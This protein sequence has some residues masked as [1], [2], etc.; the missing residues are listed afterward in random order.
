MQSVKVIFNTSEAGRLALSLDWKKNVLGPIDLWPE[1]LKTIVSL[2]FSSRFPMFIIWGPRRILLYNDAY[3]EL[4]GQKHPKAFGEEFQTIWSKN[5]SDVEAHIKSAEQG[6]AVYLENVR[7]IL[8]RDNFEEETFFTF[9]YSPIWS[10]SGT[11]DGLHGTCIET[12]AGI[13]AE[14]KLREN[15][16]RLRATFEHTSLGVI[17]ISLDGRFLDANK[18]FTNM[19]GRSREELSRFS[20]LDITH[21][22]D[23]E[24]THTKL[25]SLLSGKTKSF[26]IEKRYLRKDGDYFWAQSTVSLTKDEL[27]F[28]LHIVAVTED[29]TDRKSSQTFLEQKENELRTFAEKAVQS[30]SEL[31]DTLESMSDAFFSVD[32]NWIITRVNQQHEATS[33]LGRQHQIG[34]SFID[35]WFPDAKYENT[36]YLQSYRKAMNERVPVT[37]EDYYKPLKLW[38]AVRVY[39]K[40]DGGLAVFFTD[41]TERKNHDL[42]LATERQRLDAMVAESASAIGLMRGPDLIFEVAN[43]KWTGLVSPRDYM[44]KKYAEVYPELVGTPVHKSFLEVFKTGIP[45]VANEMKF[46]VISPAGNFEEQYF[47]YSTIRLKDEDGHSYGVY[48]NALNV[49]ERVR[50]RQAIEKAK[51]EVEL[52]AER[53]D[54]ERAK[55]EAAFQAVAEGIFIFDSDGASVFINEAAAKVFGSED[56]DR[57]KTRKNY[58]EHLELYDMN[59]CLISPKEWPLAR[60]LRGDS[61]RDWQIKAHRTDTGDRWIWSCSGQPATQPASELN[62]AVVVLRNITDQKVA[63]EK[64]TE[65]ERR[66]KVALQ[67]IPFPVMMHADDGEVLFLNEYWEKITGYGINEIKTIRDWT[68]RAY[69]DNKEKEKVLAHVQQLYSLTHSI[70]EGAFTIR[71]KTGEK[72][73]WEFN[74]TPIGKTA[75]GRRTVLSTAR[76]VTE[77]KQAEAKR[78]DIERDLIHAKED[79]ERANQLKSAFLANMSHEIRTPLGVMIGFADLISDASIQPEEREQFA[80]T[81][82]RNGEQLSVLINDILDLSKVEAGYLKIEIMEFSLRSLI[83]DIAAALAVKATEKGLELKT[84]FNKTFSDTVTSDPTRVRQIL[85]NLIGNAIKFTERGHIA[86]NVTEGDGTFEIEVED[87]GI[88]IREKDQQK[89]FRPFSQADE[90]MTRKY[91]GTGLGLILSRRLSEL[92]GG[93]LILKRSTPHRGSTFLFTLKNQFHDVKT[94]KKAPAPEAPFP[95]APVSNELALDGMKVLLTEDS[96]DNQRLIWTLLTREGAVVEIANNGAEGVEKALRGQYDVVLMDIQMPVLDGYAATQRLRDQGYQKPIIALTAHAMNDVRMRC[97][98]V[99]CTDHLPKPINIKKLV[100]TIVRHVAV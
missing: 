84:N 40:S 26:K 22:D 23:R 69:D 16:E 5:W 35:I 39:P 79:A 17:L 95:L 63:D 10:E 21:P 46:K 85:W 45:F 51:A 44:G 65:S 47:D 61:F 96:S 11:V 4:I 48:C 27:G 59:D 9:S 94:V 88:G 90:S 7:F 62:L 37:F 6:Q 3:A 28:P 74:S 2:M 54:L 24:E 78:K 93:Q 92:L 58:F 41:I 89:L 13:V 19:L 60:V 71:T 83:S 72:R 34:K 97:M 29:I 38:T 18:S 25:E 100:A 75:V 8:D 56:A 36:M 91:G 82:R 33:K 53:A 67:D 50:A 86:I 99:G 76:D 49:T 55:F 14:R 1:N 15:Q 30:E 43:K 64:L 12:T 20:V 87:T 81:L 77:S 73:I 42:V 68:E 70:F 66:F 32:K 80:E 57:V 31:V 52:E 98:D